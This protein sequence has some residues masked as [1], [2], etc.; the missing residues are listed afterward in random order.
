MV[1]EREEGG[2]EIVGEKL[3]D[4][5]FEV[6]RVVELRRLKVFCFSLSLYI[7]TYIYIFR[8]GGNVLCCGRGIG[9]RRHL[10]W[11]RAQ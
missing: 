1:E 9:G 8:G 7:Y 6:E 11:R 4:G 10:E 2:L 3:E 5:V